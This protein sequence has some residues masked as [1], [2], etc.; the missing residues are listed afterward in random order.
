MTDLSPNNSPEV[1]AMVRGMID[2]NR[3]MVLGTTEPAGLP[4]LC[5]VYYTHHEYRAF[6]WVSAADAQHSET[7]ARKS[8]IAI[9]IFDSSVDPAPRERFTV[10]EPSK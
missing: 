9:V 5:P 4:R 3:F 1:Q 2:T 6:Y 10:E 7:I 8:A